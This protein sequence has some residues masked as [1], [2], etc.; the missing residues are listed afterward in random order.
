MTAEALLDALDSVTWYNGLAEIVLSWINLEAH[1]GII[2]RPDNYGLCSG[3]AE[4]NPDWSYHQLQVIWMIGVELFGSYGM[5]P[6]F[7]WIENEAGFKQW[8]HDIT[9]TY[10][11]SDEYEN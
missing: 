7:G 6:R 3:D 10:R 11:E 9:K 1:E 8:V 5:S 4:E 2:S